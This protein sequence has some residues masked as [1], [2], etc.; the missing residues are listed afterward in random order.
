MPVILPTR[1]VDPANAPPPLYRDLFLK[2]KKL[3]YDHNE[4]FQK[5]FKVSLTSFWDI[6]TGFKYLNFN[7]FLNV[8]ENKSLKQ[9]IQKKYG[10]RGVELVMILAGIK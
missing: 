2:N 1:P 9:T 6:N 4:E 3:F 5:I 10:K 7:D 8:P